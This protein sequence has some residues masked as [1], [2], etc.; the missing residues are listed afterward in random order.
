MIPGVATFHPRESWQDPR[1][2]VSGPAADLSTVDHGVVHYTGADNVI[3]GD[4]GESA[5]DLPG[6]HRSMQR[7]YINV[8]GYSLGY[9]FSVDWLGG[10]WEIRGW[11][12]RSAANAGWNH[13]SVAVLVLV[14]GNDMASPY[15]V[16]SVQAVIAEATRRAGRRLEIKGHGQ[17]RAETG[18]GSATSCPGLGLQAQINAG[19][20]SPRPTPIPPELIDMQLTDYYVVTFSTIRPGAFLV[21]PGGPVHIDGQMRDDYLRAGAKRVDSSNAEVLASYER[22]ARGLAV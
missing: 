4:P 14:D 22:V 13:R 18:V 8:R 11:R 3:D 19:V 2:P 16:R 21:G 9:N 12:F 17:L 7:H 1:Y 6:F 5:G 15:A 10:V 20:F